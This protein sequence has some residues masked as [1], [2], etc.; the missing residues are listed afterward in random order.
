MGKDP[1]P[2]M[3]SGVEGMREEVRG[4]R[5]AIRGISE[6]VSADKKASGVTSYNVAT[7]PMARGVVDVLAQV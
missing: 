7:A 2:G 1:R 3:E 6:T 4:W 5:A